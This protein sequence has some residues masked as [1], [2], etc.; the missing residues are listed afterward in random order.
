MTFSAG[1]TSGTTRDGLAAMQ[2]DWNARIGRRGVPARRDWS[3]SPTSRS[4][5]NAPGMRE[6]PRRQVGDGGRGDVAQSV[7]P[8]LGNHSRVTVRHSQDQLAL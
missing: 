4:A 7:A 3:R 5:T 1:I 6:L 8:R 2:R